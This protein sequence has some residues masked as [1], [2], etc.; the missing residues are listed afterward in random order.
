MQIEYR[1]KPDPWAALITL[2]L[3]IAA[4]VIV[5]VAGG[6]ASAPDVRVMA[7]RCDV[8]HTDT[9]AGKVRCELELLIEDERA[10]AMVETT[11]EEEIADRCVLGELHYGSWVFG[12]LFV[13]PISAE[14]CEEDH[15]PFGFGAADRPVSK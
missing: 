4:L 2:A 14:A 10:S 6:C 3:M 9:M 15:A 12:G 13:D 11:L 7:A 1:L 8:E 5:A